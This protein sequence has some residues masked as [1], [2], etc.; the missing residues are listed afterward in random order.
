[1]EKIA[2]EQKWIRCPYCGAKH[3]IHDDTA[4]CEGVYLKCTR[5]C[6]RIFELV[7]KDGEQIKSNLSDGLSV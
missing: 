5:G 1:M 3:S 2:T 4:N 7:I 6:K